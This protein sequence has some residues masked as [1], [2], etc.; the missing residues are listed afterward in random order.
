MYRALITSCGVSSVGVPLTVAVLGPFAVS[1]AARPVAVTSDRLRSVLAVLALSA[2]EAV[3]IDRLAT[4]VWGESQPDNARRALQ[5]Y[6]TRLRAVLGHAAIR[7]RSGGYLLDVAPEQVDARR[8]V[9]L[10]D[11]AGR[12]P[13]RAAQRAGL[14]EALALWR[15]TPFTDFRSAWL[16]DVESAQ[17]LERYLTGMERLI[18]IDIEDGHSSEVVAQLGVLTAH[19]PLR[20]RFW[21][22]LMLA[23]SRAG[24]QGEALEAYQ[25][26][27]RL[28]ADELGVEPDQAVQQLHRQILV[29]TAPP[30]DGPQPAGPS[31][32]AH[33]S[34]A[35]SARRGPRISGRAGAHPASADALPAFAAV[36]RQ[37]PLETRDFVGRTTELAYLD[38]RLGSQTATGRPRIV[39]VSGMA[40]VGKTGLILRWAHRAAAHFPDGQLFADLNGYAT[41]SPVQPGQVLGSFLRAWGVPPAAVPSDVTE[42]AGLY[43]TILAHRRVLIVLDNARTTDQVRALLPGDS[44][45]VVVI[46]SRHRMGGIQAGDG[47]HLLNVNR[48]STAEAVTLLASLVP[49]ECAEAE[50]EALRVLAEH[51]AGLPLAIRICAANLASRPHTTVGNLVADMDVQG[52]LVNLVPDDDDTHAVTAA[53]AASHR[54]LS[55]DAQHAFDLLGLV[56]LRDY[57]VDAA[58]ALAGCPPVHARRIMRE[59]GAA[60][61]LEQPGHD[62]YRFHDLV[63]EFAETRAESLGRHPGAD[64]VLYWY[65]HAAYQSYRQ[66]YPNG[67]AGG[68]DP[69]TAPE[70][71]LCFSSIN[72]AVAW[73]DAERINLLT[74]ISYAA[75][76]QRHDIAAQLSSFLTSYFDLTKRWDDWI[77]SHTIGAQSAAA[78][79]D[80]GLQ[81][82]LINFVGVAVGQRQQLDQAVSLHEQALDI[83]RSIG[84]LKQE[85]AI[86]NSLG[87]TTKN[88]G[89]KKQAIEFHSRALTLRRRLD[90]ADGVSISLSNIAHVYEEIGEYAAAI[91]HFR[92]ALRLQEALGNGQ[93]MLDILDGLAIAYL[94]S[95]ETDAAELTLNQAIELGRSLRYRWG[96]ASALTTLGHLRMTTGR[97]DDARACWTEALDI[98]DD[99]GDPRTAELTELVVALPQAAEHS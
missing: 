88:L 24:R 39:V 60:H 49:A 94:H 64:R 81:A 5:V 10:L 86:L 22:Q 13:D 34:S 45:S 32:D 11:A 18:D 43:R 97:V 4:A 33:P 53:F 65:L 72:D 52:R 98:F 19:Y 28:L 27:H 62:R 23:L 89:R 51:C 85:A 40:G 47:A 57:S 44:N 74:V 16:A 9:Q 75:H 93:T 59:L 99:L 2:G 63:R 1:V 84:D 15:G 17:L 68:P 41:T 12:A 37:L 42:A 38:A 73:C 83:C 35:T 77:S 91:Q 69:S 36:P 21:G 8:F 87:I 80:K 29:D 30:V 46:A 48:L 95:G 90:D 54:L 31:R 7:S 92:E 55:V 70:H 79:G 66:I 50:P 3:S 61:L 14:A 25:R 76:H 58:G 71:S 26:L 78:I 82:R 56:P 6:V 20:E 96:I 67:S